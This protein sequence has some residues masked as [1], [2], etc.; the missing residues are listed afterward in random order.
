[1]LVV[2]MRVQTVVESVFVSRERVCV[3]ARDE[4]RQAEL[5]L[6]KFGRDKKIGGEVGDQFN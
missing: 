1:M 3:Y 4:S 5:R 6:F 2:V